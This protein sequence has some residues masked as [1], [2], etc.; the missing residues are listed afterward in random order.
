MSPQVICMPGGIAP[1]AQ[2]YAPLVAAVGGRADL[3]LKDL[4]VYAGGT[5]PADYSIDQE[6]AAL[7][8]FHLV[9]YSGGGFISL[10]YAGT[11]PERVLSLALFEPAMVPGDMTADERELTDAFR[12]KLHGLEG[13]PLMSAFV[14]PV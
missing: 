6:V 2:R 11:R 7:D 12:S 14:R 13:E 1:A 9:G 3:H 4:E 5:P 10:A 8:R